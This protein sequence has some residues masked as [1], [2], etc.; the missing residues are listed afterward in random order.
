M[1]ANINNAKQIWQDCFE[2]GRSR[3]LNTTGDRP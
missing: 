2:K 3:D 1:M